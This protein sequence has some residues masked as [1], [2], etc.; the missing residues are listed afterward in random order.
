MSSLLDTWSRTTESMM[1]FRRDCAPASEA[2]LSKN[3]FASAMRQRAVV[4]TQMNSR[5]LVGIWFGSPSQM[6][7]RFSNRRTSCTKGSLKCSPAWVTGSP[8]GQQDF[9]NDRLLALL[10]GVERAKEHE[11]ERHHEDNDRSLQLLYRCGRA[12]SAPGLRG[13]AGGIC[14][15]SCG[16]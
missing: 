14:A 7:R 10:Q 15:S 12:L 1:S 4:S 5:P 9:H 6:R 2:T 3:F 16:R 13:D 11:E 8:T